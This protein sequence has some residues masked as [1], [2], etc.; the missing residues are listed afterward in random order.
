M[1]FYHDSHKKLTHINACVGFL[2]TS[3]YVTSTRLEYF[4]VTLRIVGVS[5][6]TLF[7]VD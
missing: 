6:D 3:F 4:N 5:F 1:G 2:I 7:N